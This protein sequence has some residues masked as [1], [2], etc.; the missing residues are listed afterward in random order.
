MRVEHG[1]RSLVYSGDSGPCDQL[2]DLAASADLFLCEASF[3]DGDDNPPDVH[4]TGREAGLLA[5]R[6][7]VDRLVVTHVPPWHDP[8]QARTEARASY[9]GAVELA[10]SGASYEI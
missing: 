9:D 1:D 3:R 8:A 6:A 4:L 2:V 10:R 7:S 5:A